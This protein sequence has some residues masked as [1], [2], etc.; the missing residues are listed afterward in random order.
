[1]NYTDATLIITI[2]KNEK[3]VTQL[4]HEVDSAVTL[5]QYMNTKTHQQKRQYHL[6]NKYIRCLDKVVVNYA[7]DLMNNGH[8]S[9][10][11]LNY[12]EQVAKTL[13]CG[14]RY[15]LQR[16]ITSHKPFSVSLIRDIFVEGGHAIYNHTGMPYLFGFIKYC[17]TTDNSFKRSGRF[18]P[19]YSTYQ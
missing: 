3:Q 13:E 18:K 7:R 8:T 4:D 1:M 10:S 9:W 5:K 6:C 14:D 15:Q 12:F 17:D 11:D 2:L 19:V 16:S